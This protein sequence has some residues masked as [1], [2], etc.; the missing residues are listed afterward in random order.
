VIVA[1]HP[2]CLP[3][4]KRRLEFAGKEEVWLGHADKGRS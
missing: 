3:P 4:G 1:V 2:G